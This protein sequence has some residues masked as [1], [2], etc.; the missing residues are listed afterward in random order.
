A[1]TSACSIPRGRCAC[2]SPALAS[3]GVGEGTVDP[4]HQ[5]AQPGADL[6][7]GMLF[8][9]GAQL[10]EVRPAVVILGDPLAGE[11]AVLDLGEDP[12]HLVFDLRCDDSRPP[13]EVAVL[14]GV[15]DRVTH[16]GDAALI[17]QIDDELDLVQAFEI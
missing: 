11:A 5:P 1:T 8:S 3:R 10:G 12:A 16:P 2:R 13:G 6:L 4:G 14:G 15:G 17:N 7:D 9:L